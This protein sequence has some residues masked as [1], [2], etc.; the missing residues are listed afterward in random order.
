MSGMGLISIILLVVA[1]TIILFT[2]IYE[3]KLF[4]KTSFIVYESKL[5]YKYCIQKMCSSANNH[6]IKMNSD[7]EGILEIFQMKGA[8]DK[9]N[10]TVTKFYI[11][12]VAVDDK[13]II[14]L[15]SH[16]KSCSQLSKRNLDSFMLA[17]INAFPIAN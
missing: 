13:T 3:E 10:F 15:S 6:L 4:V 2:N 12:F 17:T 9:R 5:Y 16:N 8:K 14:A 1:I 11:F 7:R